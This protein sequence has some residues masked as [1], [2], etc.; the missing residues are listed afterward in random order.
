MALPDLTGQNI[1]DTYQR[2]LQVSG[3]GLIADGTGSLFTPLN[4]TSASYADY[5][6]SASHEIILE[7]SSS[8]AETASFALTTVSLF[9]FTGDAQITGSLTI[10][11][12]FSSFTLDSDNVILGAGTGT[13]MEAGANSN[14][15][16]GSNTA[17]SLTT[18]DYNVILGDSAG[19]AITNAQKNVLI[20]QRAGGNSTSLTENV[21]IGNAAGRYGSGLAGNVGIGQDALKGTSN[22]NGDYNIGIGWQS[23]L[24]IEDGAQNV[25][26]GYRA[27]EDITTGNYNVVIGRKSGFELTTGENNIAIGPDAGNGVSTGNRNIAIGY[28]AS[29][30]GNV[31]DQLI[32]G[33]GSLATISA[34]LATGD[35]IF[36]STA[37]ADYF[38]GDGSQLTNLPSPSGKFGITDSSGSYTYYSDLSSSLQ[39]ATAGDTIQL[40]T[41]VTESSDHI[42]H[43]KDGV[44]FNFNGYELFY[45]ASAALDAKDIFGDNNVAVTSSFYNG[46]IRFTQGTGVNIFNRFLY[47]QNAGTLIKNHGFTWNVENGS[48]YTPYYPIDNNGTIDG[49][50]IIGSADVVNYLIHNRRV[51][52]NLEVKADKTGIRNAGYLVGLI[53]NCQIY[54]YGGNATYEASHGTIRNSYIYAA[55]GTACSAYNIYSC[56]VKADAGA[57]VT[58]ARKLFNTVVENAG[59][60]GVSILGYMIGGSI[61]TSG[62]QCI[63]VADSC[64]IQGVQIWNSLYTGPAIEIG[65]SILSNCS[66]MDDYPYS[67][68]KAI[69]VV[70]GATSPKIVNCSFKFLNDSI[71]NKA[72][73]A[74][75][76]DTSVFYGNNT[77]INC[78][79]TNPTKV[80]QAITNTPDAQGNLSINN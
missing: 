73:T 77:F 18:G 30:S 37:S 62:D 23:G 76:D 33:S 17:T 35:I 49:G 38:S 6:V 13:S 61:H 60:V 63:T 79:P 36:P 2:V 32:I 68:Q 56:V 45:S 15:I 52:K 54:S 59:G 7:V 5:A 11:G 8:Y 58:S 16:I 78:T 22:N 42:Y 47:I 12:S 21:F 48:N 40:F 69:E 9:P 46:S 67:G 75:D 53:D 31:S 55:T 28:S 26:I 70:T 51:L 65:N 80:T 20:G 66:L 1:Q 4:A 34:S 74:V 14:I 24:S 27:A 50:K 39:A 64:E 10:S 43:F 19:T 44:D 41:N 57:G 3:S 72:I 25:F 29:F 71:L